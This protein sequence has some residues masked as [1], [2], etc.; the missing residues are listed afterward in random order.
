MG[1]S[2]T[3]K[4]TITQSVCGDNSYFK[5]DGLESKMEAYYVDGVVYAKTNGIKVKKEISKEEYY[6]EYLGDSANE[7][8]ILDIPES[9]FSGIVIKPDGDN[10]YLQFSIDGEKYSEL[11]GKTGVSVEISGD[12]DYRVYFDKEGN[13][14]KMTTDFEMGI[15]GFMTSTKAVSIF[16]NIGTTEPIKAPADADSYSAVK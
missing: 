10:Y 3:V 16:K 8:K 13:I 6:K 1:E 5:L 4:Q 2:Q 7:D 12:V 9:W 14:I 11:I 15:E